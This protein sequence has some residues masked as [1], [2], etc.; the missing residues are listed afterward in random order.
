MGTLKQWHGCLLKPN[1]ITERG[2]VG[3]TPLHWAV[4]FGHEAIVSQ[5]LAA[6]PDLIHTVNNANL[7]AFQTALVWGLACS[8]G[9]P[10]LAEDV[11]PSSPT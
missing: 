10:S 5:L 6:S 3:W 1:L 4:Q 2:N 11:L 8:A 7:T 9:K